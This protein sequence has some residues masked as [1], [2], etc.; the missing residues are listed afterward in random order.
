M[1]LTNIEHILLV[2]SGKGGVG[3]SSVTTQLA[4]S[5]TLR[6]YNVGVLDVDL[7]GP[8]IPRFFG[9]E[10]AKIRQ[11]AG[12][13]IPVVAHEGGVVDEPTSVPSSN[14]AQ[15]EGDA[16]AA[17]EESGARKTRKVG[18]L[19]IMSLGFLLAT[20]SSA[21]IWRGPKKT[22][23]VR[24]FLSDVAWP[25]LDYLLIDTP[26]GT[27]DEHISLLETLVQQTTPTYIPSEQQPPGQGRL[28]HLAGAVLVTTPQAVATSDVRKE[29]SFC[30]KTRTHVV[31]V[32]ENMAGF[33]CPHCADCA[34]IF[35]KGG[36][37][38]MA[39]DWN[40]PFLGGAPL[41]PQFGALIEEGRI[42]VYPKGT[43]VEGVDMGTND[44]A[45]DGTVVNDNTSAPLAAK[46]MRCSLWPTFDG[47]VGKIIADVEQRAG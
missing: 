18:S 14:S 8:S 35:G 15:Q 37:E 33:V 27:S 26:P 4:L 13:L 39:N 23:M 44:E 29:L 2:L 22:A 19:H 25:R 1:P 7:T 28:P 38:A 21:V 9:V 43:Q 24:Q 46:Y 42:P 11:G 40:V 5:L 47:V 45:T 32:L 31:G 41:D 3:K 20:R 6:G 30:E 36:G 12:G 17:T 34:D 16:P 10:D